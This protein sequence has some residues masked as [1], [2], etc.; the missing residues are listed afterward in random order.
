MN[1][2]PLHSA[3]RISLEAVEKL[4]HILFRDKPSSH[5]LVPSE[6][7]LLYIISDGHGGNV[8]LLGKLRDRIQCL[9]AYGDC[10]TGTSHFNYPLSLSIKKEHIS[11]KKAN[12]GGTYL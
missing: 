2:P 8:E 1:A 11:L 5:C 6:P 9:S 4:N 7:P 10:H 12:P 3:R